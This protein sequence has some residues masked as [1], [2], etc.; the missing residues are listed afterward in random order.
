[1]VSS[2]TRNARAISAVS[3]PPRARSVSATCPSN[4]SAG[5]QQ[6]KISSSRSSL[7]T[8]SSNSS[9]DGL[10]HR[11]QVDLLGQ[12]AL[13]ADPVDRPVA[14]RRHQPR[15]RV[16]RHAGYGPAL[17]RDR[18]RLLHGVL[19][20]VE[21]TE[22]PDQRRQHPAPLVA[23]DLLQHGQRC[24]TGLTSTA[25]PNRAAGMRAASSIASSRLAASTRQNPPSTSLVSANGPSVISV[26]PPTMRTQV[27]VSTGCSAAPT[28]H[29]GH[30]PTREI[31]RVHRLTFGIGQRL[32]RSRAR[33]RSSVR[34]AS[35]PPGQWCSHLDDERAA[36]LG[37][38]PGTQLQDLTLAPRPERSTRQLETL[39]LGCPGTGY[40]FVAR[41]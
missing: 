39:T 34:T 1:M 7:I 41:V 38:Q 24:T 6:V 5:W 23:E 2:E 25:P 8:V 26:R 36:A 11:Q 37:T 33:R 10:R 35:Q 17:R 12:G 4:G 28:T 40:S 29:R 20:P 22:E 9:I 13:P 21:V 27:A 32:G 3:R 16:G 15:T 19:G 18:E 14:G 31:L 30:R